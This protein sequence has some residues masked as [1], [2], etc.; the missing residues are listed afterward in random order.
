MMTDSQLAAKKKVFTVLDKQPNSFVAWLEHDASGVCRTMVFMA[1]GDSDR[2][3]IRRL[4]EALRVRDFRLERL[5]EAPH[6]D[7]EW[8]VR[9]AVAGQTKFITTADEHVLFAAQGSADIF[10]DD[11]NKAAVFTYAKALLVS[12]RL[13]RE[14]Q[15]RPDMV[16][17]MEPVRKEAAIANP[18][19][20]GVV[21]VDYLPSIDPN[22]PP[23]SAPGERPPGRAA[24]VY[25]VA[26]RES[27][28]KNQL[29][30]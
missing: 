7:G 15:A 24:T 11:P 20:I 6:Q 25:L 1:L 18:T 17:Y 12:A 8:V 21:F 3:M 5:R 30:L 29:R 13:M 19:D 9:L 2:V 4:T 26:R 23:P 14:M 22:A 10:T 27:D 16:V 28:D